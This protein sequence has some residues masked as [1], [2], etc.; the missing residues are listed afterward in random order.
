MNPGLQSVCAE[1]AACKCCGAAAFPY[2]VVDFHKNCE[3]RRRNVLDVSGVPIYYYRCPECRFLFT[4]AFDHFTRDDFLQYVYNDEY[5][6]VDPDYGDERSR[7]N[8]AV[9][10]GL[11]SGAR[12]RRILDYGGGNGS[13]ARRLRAD[14]F[15]GVETYDPFVPEFSE[16]P[17]GRFDCVVSFEVVEHSTD[18]EETFADMGE[19]LDDPGLILFSTL[20]Q[21]PDIDRHGLNWW[22]AGPRNGHV[23]LF[24][25]ESLRAIVEPLGF[26]LA[27]FSDNLH[28]LYREVPAFARRFLVPLERAAAET[29]TSMVLAG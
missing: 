8:A 26:G 19:S 1:H 7:G 13:L 2:G 27:S 24:S 22:Y 16:R 20:L 15:D 11:F 12:P 3:V 29:Y 21:P 17:S 10:T 18:P 14:G 9:L 28:V 6:L 5:L 23:S 25:R 4:T